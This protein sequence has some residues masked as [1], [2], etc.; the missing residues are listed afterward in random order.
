[1]VPTS[2]ATELAGCLAQH[3]VRVV[4]AE[5]CTAGLASALLASVPGISQFLCGSLVTYRAE[6]KQDWLGISDEILQRHSAVSPIVSQQMALAA[7]QRTSAADYGAAVTGHLG[8]EVPQA[9]MA[10][11]TS[12]W[13]FAAA[14]NPNAG[15]SRLQVSRRR[16]NRSASGSGSPGTAVPGTGCG[17]R[18]PSELRRRGG[19][20]GKRRPRDHV[21]S[22]VVVGV[23]LSDT[24]RNRSALVMTETELK[25]IAAAASMGFSSVCMPNRGPE[26]RLPAGSR[27]SCR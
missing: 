9:R 8:P 14:K 7:L 27:G 11:S 2:E 19:I 24:F 3:Q 18:S 17:E 4:F 6:C 1:M 22:P 20:I 5:S 10:V 13:P 26:F 15:T 21:E 12:P 16:T 23:R 25:L